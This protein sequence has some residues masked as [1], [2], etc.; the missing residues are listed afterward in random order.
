[1]STATVD[2]D[3][4][5]PSIPRR[6]ADALSRAV[7]S[8]WYVGRASFPDCLEDF[9]A[10]GRS[11]HYLFSRWY[12]EVKTLVDVIERSDRKGDIARQIEVKRKWAA[13]KGYRYVVA[14]DVD[15]VQAVQAAGRPG[16]ERGAPADGRSH[17]VQ[18]RPGRPP[19]A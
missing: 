10:M 7:E 17:N 4:D 15:D 11:R 3:N 16:T 8:H 9:G 13:G 19:K 1:M 2:R 12:P 18:R 6:H 14:N 5:A